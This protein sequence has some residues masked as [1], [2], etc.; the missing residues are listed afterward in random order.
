MSKIGRNDPCPCGSKKKYKKCCYN[1]RVTERTDEFGVL[2]ENK[3]ISI[4]DSI[5]TGL[6]TLLAKN[7]KLSYIDLPE[8][9]KRKTSDMDVLPKLQNFLGN[10]IKVTP[11]PNGTVQFKTNSGTI[12]LEP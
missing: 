11:L 1:M 8:K 10:N 2:R 6:A 3:T 5:G 12:V 7:L 4:E 9:E